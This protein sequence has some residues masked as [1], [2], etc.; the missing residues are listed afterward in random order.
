MSGLCDVSN[1]PLLQEMA[2]SPRESHGGE[3]GFTATRELLTPWTRKDEALAALL[4]NGLGIGADTYGVSYPGK[5][6]VYARSAVSEPVNPK[7]DLDENLDPIIELIDYSSC[8]AKL[9]VQYETA[10]AGV[11]YLPET[12]EG[13]LTYSNSHGKEA[14]LLPGRQLQFVDNNE[15]PQDPDQQFVNYKA[16]IEHRFEW[17][18]VLNPPWTAISEL[19]GHVNDGL[20]FGKVAGTLLFDGV[21]SSITAYLEPTPG[22]ALQYWKLSY[23]FREKR[24][25]DE[26]NAFAGGWNHIY[27]TNPAGW[28]EAKINNGAPPYPKSNFAPLFQAVLI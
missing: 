10:T 27:R 21:S 2:G 12:S 7:P 20:F 18:N 28:V 24:I 9:T 8:Y 3:G 14:I 26:N 16:V 15:Q 25:V 22:Q 11:P 6:G 13:Y 23:V 4:G 1:A 5:S 19:A 17:N